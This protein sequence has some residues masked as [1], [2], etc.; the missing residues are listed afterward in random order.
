MLRI[1][2]GSLYSS[3]HRLEHEGWIE[4]EWGSCDNNRHAKFYR[5]RAFFLGGVEDL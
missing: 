5:P 2:Q 4:A 3:L 1:S